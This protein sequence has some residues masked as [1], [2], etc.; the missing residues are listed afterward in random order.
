LL[1]PPYRLDGQGAIAEDVE[2]LAAIL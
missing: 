1:G 2:R